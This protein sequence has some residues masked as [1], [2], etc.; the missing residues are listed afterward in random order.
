MPCW[1][2]YSATGAKKSLSGNGGDA[3]AASF[4]GAEEGLV[5]DLAGVLDG[6]VGEAVVEGSDDDGLP[7]VADGAVGLAGAME[8]VGEAFGV[9]GGVVAYEVQEARC[10]EGFVFQAEH[11]GAEEA[12]GLMAGRGEW[13][14]MDGAAAAAGLEEGEGVVPAEGIREARL[15]AEVDQVGAAAED[16]VLG[17]DG[18]FEGGVFVGVGSAAD[19]GAALEQ[20]DFSASGGEGCQRRQSPATPAPTTMTSVAWRS[21]CHPVA[22][23]P[24]LRRA[25]GW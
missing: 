10:D 19:V 14:G 16:D 25:R 5:E 20:G 22:R 15:V 12:E 2:A 13:A 4:G 23:G 7:E 17:V 24:W 3:E 8:P 18:L 1:R 11:R 21:R 9:V 6:A